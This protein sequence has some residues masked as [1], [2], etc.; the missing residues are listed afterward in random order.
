MKARRRS[1]SHFCNAGMPS[2]RPPT[3]NAGKGAALDAGGDEIKKSLRGLSHAR[4]AVTI[5]ALFV[6]PLL[7][8][9]PLPG[10]SGLHAGGGSGLGWGGGVGPDAL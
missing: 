4:R 3:P 2:T 9:K 6:R 1:L 5:K 10:R 7:L 8:L